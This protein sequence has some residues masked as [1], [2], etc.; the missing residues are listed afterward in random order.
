MSGDVSPE[1]GACP[2]PPVCPEPGRGACWLAE[3][4]SSSPGLGPGLTPGCRE[5][6]AQ[7]GCGK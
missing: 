5:G 7:G 3:A 2:L 6:Q 1:A 4:G